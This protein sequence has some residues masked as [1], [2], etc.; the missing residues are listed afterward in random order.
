MN[1]INRLYY[2]YP[3]DNPNG[4]EIGTLLEART[5]AWWKEREENPGHCEHFSKRNRISDIL[6]AEKWHCE[7]LVDFLAKI[8]EN[9]C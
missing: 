2:F 9:N 7:P 1:K 3:L 8:N 4:I 5:A 6:L